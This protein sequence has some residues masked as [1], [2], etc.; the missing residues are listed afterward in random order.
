MVLE[1]PSAVNSHGRD[2][3]IITRIGEMFLLEIQL[4]L[5]ILFFKG[6]STTIDSSSFNSSE[7]SFRITFN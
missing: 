7:P 1:F 3:S 2:I 4:G 6:N 5:V